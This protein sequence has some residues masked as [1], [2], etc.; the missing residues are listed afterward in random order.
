VTFVEAGAEAA[1][2]GTTT[3]PVVTG[4]PQGAAA[5][6]RFSGAVARLARRASR[7]DPVRVLAIAGSVGLVAG[8]VLVGLGWYDASGQSVVAKQLPYLVSATLP[9]A[10]LAIL[11][12]LMLPTAMWVANARAMGVGPLPVEMPGTASSGLEAATTPSAHPG[13]GLVVTPQGRL[14][15]RPD[16]PVVLHRGDIKAA[17]GSGPPCRVCNPEVPTPATAGGATATRTK[18]AGKGTGNVRSAGRRG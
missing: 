15:H 4:E 16:C 17:R 5:R 12:G 14:V 9:G 11:G 3:P 13:S 10:V 18:V 1:T 7:L 6:D 8:I 2:L